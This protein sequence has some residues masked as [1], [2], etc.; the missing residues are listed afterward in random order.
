M[1]IV[2]VV[3]QNADLAGVAPLVDVLRCFTLQDLADLLVLQAFLAE[4]LYPLR[5]L[6]RIP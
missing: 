4:L 2:V 3:D 6:V 1:L 5:Q